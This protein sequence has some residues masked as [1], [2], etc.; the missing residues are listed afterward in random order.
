[1][2]PTWIQIW[3][4]LFYLLNKIFFGLIIAW[5]GRGAEPGWLDLVARSSVGI[6]LLLSLYE[7]GGLKYL[8]QFLELAISAG[9]LLGTYLMAKDDIR[10]YFWLML[11][12][13]ACASL[14]G[15]QSY[16]ILMLQQLL[17]LVFVIDACRIRRRYPRGSIGGHLPAGGTGRKAF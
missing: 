4:G 8:S 3:A 2:N 6:G 7:F 5:K 9:F 13:V 10:G 1:M 12:N 17:S 15:I 14:M 11:G 16:W